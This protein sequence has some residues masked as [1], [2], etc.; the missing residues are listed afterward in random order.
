MFFD[1]KGVVEGKEVTQTDNHHEV[2]RARQ[3]DQDRE[4]QRL[5]NWP[6][7]TERL[8]LVSFVLFLV[9]FDFFQKGNKADEGYQVEKYILSTQ[10]HL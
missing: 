3:Q 4:D 1:K 6:P 7:I 5:I 2:G 9:L 10:S 8:K